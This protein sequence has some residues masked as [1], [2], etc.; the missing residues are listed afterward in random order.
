MNFKGK[1]TLNYSPLDTTLKDG[2]VLLVGENSGSVYLE[3]YNDLTPY[4]TSVELGQLTGNFAGITAHGDRVFVAAGNG[5]IVSFD[6]DDLLGNLEETEI[7]TSDMWKSTSYAGDVIVR[8]YTNGLYAYVSANDGL[9]VFD[10]DETP[11]L[12]NKVEFV[13]P[14]YRISAPQQ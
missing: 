2:Y 4:A 10:V 12:M 5:G 9:Y 14:L 7:A 1:V 3:A 11:A 8:A 6:F 13:S